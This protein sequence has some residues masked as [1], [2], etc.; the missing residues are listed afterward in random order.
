MGNDSLNVRDK[1]NT[2]ELLAKDSSLLEARDTGS[3][4][5]WQSDNYIKFNAALVIPEKTFAGSAQT[6]VFGDNVTLMSYDYDADGNVIEK[7]NR[8]F[9]I[10]N[11]QEL[12]D[13]NDWLLGKSS[14]AVEKPKREE[15]EKGQKVSQL[16]LWLDFKNNNITTTKAVQDEY[17]GLIGKLIDSQKPSDELTWDYDVWTDSLSHSN[18]ATAGRGELHAIYAN[19]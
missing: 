11:T 2:I 5:N 16:Q 12:A 15:E 6:S 1:A 3:Q 8:T 13:F 14:D 4:V 17:A 10:T 19:G 7:A 9:T 18:N